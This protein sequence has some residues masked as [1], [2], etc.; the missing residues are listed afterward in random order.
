MRNR[1]DAEEVAIEK[2]RTAVDGI[3]AALARYWETQRTPQANGSLLAMGAAQQ[4]FKAARKE[5]NVLVEDIRK[6]RT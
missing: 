4:E 6:G 1:R 2:V 3:E 5:M